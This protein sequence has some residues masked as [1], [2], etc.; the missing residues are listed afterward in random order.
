M[1]EVLP[2]WNGP[3]TRLL[4]PKQL[5][6]PIPQVGKPLSGDFNFEFM[7]QYETECK[8]T[9]CPSVWGD[10]LDTEEE[11][12]IRRKRGFKSPR[13]IEAPVNS[14]MGRFSE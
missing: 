8:W 5:S 11:V 10:L 2:D 7:A 14:Q 3:T 13:S 4:Q 9:I 6:R 1:A 12:H